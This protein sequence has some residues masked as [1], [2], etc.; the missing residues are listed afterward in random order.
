M[1][2]FGE[3]Y[4]EQTVGQVTMFDRIIFKGHL[5]GLY[6]AQKQF[7]WYLHQQGVQLKDYKAYAEQTTKELKEH[8]QSLAEQAGCEVHYLKTGQGPKGESKGELASQI[9]AEKEDQE[10]LMAIFSTLELKHS[11]TVRG[12]RE[13][14]HLD[15]VSEA[16][17]QLHY[18][19]YYKDAEFGLMYVRVQSWWPFEI[20]IYINGHQWLARQLDQAGLKYLLVDNAFWEIED[21]A[22]AQELADKFAHRQWERVWNA[23]ARQVNPFLA[24]IKEAVHKGYY[25]SIQQ[26]EIATD[27]IFAEVETLTAIMPDL[28]EEVLLTFSAQ[29]V[30]RFL[31]R[32]LRGNF[33]GEIRTDLN[34]R[35]P[36]WRVKHWVKQNSLKMYNRGPVLRIETTINNSREF[37]LPNEQSASR[38]W[39]PMPKGVAHFWHFYQAGS[40]A[41][42]RY[43][44]ALAPL[45]F[46]GKAAQDALDR[47]CQSQ[48]YHDQRVAKFQ[49]VSE[50]DC[51]LFAAVLSGDHLLHG[52]RNRHLVQALYPQPSDEPAERKRRCARI[53]RLIAKLRGHTLVQQVKHSH[54][55]LV[56][57]Y[58]YQV[59][60]AA[61]RF[62]HVDF[63][64][65]F[66]PA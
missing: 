65:F 25:W 52:F 19:L 6:P 54:L 58:G 32:P 15:V 48:V 39:K 28:F 24:R 13:T 17:K 1:A 10:G 47:L 9:L 34:K 40:Q 46:K 23:F 44:H 7:D 63:P 2:T 37:H 8:L 5:S 35:L 43:L 62:R 12:N 41:N 16:R 57:S 61:L 49:P 11:F 27:V 45:P 4:P 50:P 60:A 33:Q 51:Q 36:G 18:Y 64:A 38:R 21:V 26:A 22:A 30:M 59:M 55:Y 29:Q 53:S 3:I 66:Q 42:H 31:G 14:H 56:T 20:Q